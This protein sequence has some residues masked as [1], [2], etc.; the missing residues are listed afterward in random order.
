M[1]PSPFIRCAKPCNHSES[2]FGVYSVQSPVA[3][4][5]SEVPRIP[6][7]VFLDEYLQEIQVSWFIRS[8]DL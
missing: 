8:Y 3:Q 6:F 4:L 7:I 5:A 1:S 2:R